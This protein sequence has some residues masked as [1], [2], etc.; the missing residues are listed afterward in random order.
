MILERF[1]G[2]C[3]SVFHI[4]NSPTFHCMVASRAVESASLKFGRNQ[5]T[6]DKNQIKPDKKSDEIRKS[7]KIGKIVVDLNSDSTALVAS[8]YHD[9]K[10]FLNL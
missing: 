10:I 2:N 9:L 6:S 8:S 4:K 3:K 5:K 1:I 7:E